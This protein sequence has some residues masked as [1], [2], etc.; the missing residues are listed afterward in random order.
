[1]RFEKFHVS[2][3]SKYDFRINWLEKRAFQ[4]ACILK[5]KNSSSLIRQW[6]T[7]YLDTIKFDEDV[8]IIIDTKYKYH[9]NYLEKG[10]HCILGVSEDGREFFL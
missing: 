7:D 6:V 5:H 4:S 8:L 2:K 10:S 9:D 1:M 3:N